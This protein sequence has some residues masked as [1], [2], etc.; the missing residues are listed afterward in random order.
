[1]K[2]CGVYMNF[3]FTVLTWVKA[4]DLENNLYMMLL[5]LV[6]LGSKAKIAPVKLWPNSSPVYQ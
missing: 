2:N 6:D 1:M 3:S 4:L 5:I